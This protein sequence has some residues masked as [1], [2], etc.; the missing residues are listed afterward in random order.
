[1]TKPS[2]FI[3]SSSEGLELARACRDLLDT[4]AEITLWNEGFFELGHTFIETLV[5]SLPRFD[6]AVLILSSD[7]LVTSRDIKTFGPRDNVIFELGL[8]MGRLGRSRT[9][10]VCQRDAAIKIPTDLSGVT[11][12]TYEPR[13]DGNLEAALGAACDKIRK[14]I[15]EL[16][17]SE[18]KTAK[19]IRNIESRQVDQ[20]QHLA[21]QEA[22]LRAIQIALRGIVTNY[23]LEK[24]IFLTKDEPFL[25]HYSDDLIDELRHLRAIGLIQN[26]QGI[27]LRDIAR[28]YK[29]RNQQFDLKR[30]FFITEQ[31]REYLKFRVEGM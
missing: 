27:G 9:F 19:A 1:M 18:A 11:T 17:V 20:E 15:R 2:A 10:I 26:H 28:D 12:A 13:E 5:N 30:F 24:L 29:D 4:D 21:K 25:C 22:E 8:F 7:D 31:G 16:G 23:E 3:G 14:A 6:F